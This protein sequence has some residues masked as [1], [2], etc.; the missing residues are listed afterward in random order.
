ML[1]REQVTAHISA[2]ME[3]VQAANAQ[4]IL[5]IDMTG[6]LNYDAPLPRAIEALID[7]YTAA[8]SQI[9][10]DE[11]GWLEYFRYNCTFGANPMGVTPE[12][13]AAEIH[14]NSPEAI[15]RVICWDR[16]HGEAAR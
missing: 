13:G 14:I 6:D 3:S 9:I 2:W 12:K 16:E 5:L 7:G 4:L 10:G 1:N 8:L 15:A 11:C